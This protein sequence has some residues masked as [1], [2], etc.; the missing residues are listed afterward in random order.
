[1][2]EEDAEKCLEIN[3]IIENI[4]D[5]GSISGNF[6]ELIV[7]STKVKI[8]YRAVL[9]SFKATIFS[10]TRKLTR[11]KPNRRAGFEALGSKYEF[12]SRLL[13]AIDVSGSISSQSVRNFLGI[14]NRFFAFRVKKIEVVQFDAEI[15]GEVLTMKKA[16]KTLKIK[17]RGGTD[18]QPVYDFVQKNNHYDG[19]IFFTDGYAPEPVIKFRP[20]ARF[21]WILENEDCYNYHKKRLKKYGKVTFIS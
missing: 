20:K 11:M 6:Q 8:D 19:V 7:A 9:R 5:W 10:S 2:W 21:L 18:F 14:I 12:S 3:E 15:K 13:V 4:K 1:M 17:G 16:Q